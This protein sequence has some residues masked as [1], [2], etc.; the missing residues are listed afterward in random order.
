MGRRNTSPRR[1]TR[2]KKRAENQR[3]EWCSAISAIH[4]SPDF[5]S[6]TNSPTQRKV[7]FCAGVGQSE[8]PQ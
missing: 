5:P 8:Y 6:I 4:C 1:E 3:A 2:A 7:V